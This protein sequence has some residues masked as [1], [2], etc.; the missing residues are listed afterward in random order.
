VRPTPTLWIMVG[1]LLGF[2]IIAVVIG[3][4]Y[5]IGRI[6][7]LGANGQY[8][9]ARLAFF[10]L[11]P[12]LLFGVLSQADLTRMFS[13]QLPIAA[14]AAV[15]C[16]VLF[17]IWGIARRLSVPATTIGALGSGYVN[18][19]NIGIPVS[20]YVLGD[21]SASAPVILLQVVILAPIVL[22]IL[23]LSTS[24]KLSLGR[25]L[26]QPVRNPMIIASVLG[27]LVAV[28]GLEIPEPVLEPL[29]LIGAAAVPVILL[30]F[31]MSLH[32]ARVLG[33]ESPRADVLVA[34]ALKVAAMPVLAWLVAHVVFGLD[35]QALF[36]AVALAALPGAQNIFNY[37]QRYATNEI[38]ARD[39]VLLT[40]AL[41]LPTVLVVAALLAPR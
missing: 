12:A 28:T 2:A 37:A 27:M 32:G 8:V 19:N 16:F 38:F 9:L 39:V 21:A 1:V 34:T 30:G 41:S 14:L 36:A 23:D 18:A 17:T 35:G 24:G 13:V 29:L 10:V 11:N 7:L 40:T 26:L 20:V 25:I 4:G 15:G 31:G 3:L 5:V 6:D 22:T 33:P